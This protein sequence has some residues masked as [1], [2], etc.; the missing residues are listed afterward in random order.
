L[1]NELNNTSNNA[2]FT[3]D[4]L[5]FNLKN[6]L[7]FSIEYT[8]QVVDSYETS[9]IEQHFLTCS[10][11]LEHSIHKKNVRFLIAKKLF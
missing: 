2:N 4:N 3:Y 6:F 8:N 9:L 7:D 1:T 10:T 11:T 5:L